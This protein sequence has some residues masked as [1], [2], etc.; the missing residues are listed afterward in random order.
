MKHIPQ[1]GVKASGMDWQKQRKAKRAQYE[2]HAASLLLTDY[3][4]Q[5]CMGDVQIVQP[6]KKGMK[7]KSSFLR[8]IGLSIYSDLYLILLPRL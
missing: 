2:V 1:G 3:T 7:D 8:T 5:F 6:M 4:I